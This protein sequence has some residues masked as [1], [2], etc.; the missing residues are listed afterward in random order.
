MYLSGFE[1]DG[2]RYSSSEHYIQAKKAKLF[3]DDATQTK[4]LNATSPYET[5]CLGAKVKQFDLDTWKCCAKDIVMMAVTSKFQQNATMTEMLKKKQWESKL[6]KLVEI[7]CA[8]QVC[9]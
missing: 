7:I 6:W 9:H 4:I 5:K 1:K 2:V 3:N 8:V